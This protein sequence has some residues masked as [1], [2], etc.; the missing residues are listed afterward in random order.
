MSKVYETTEKGKDPFA[1]ERKPEAKYEK[2]SKFT[3]M[4][5]TAQMNIT[6]EPNPYSK[7]VINLPAG[8]IVEVESFGKEWCKV[9]NG[10]VMSVFLVKA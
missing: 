8:S 10:F 1:S 4:K 6:A 7:V 5:L 2:V 3:P 9:K